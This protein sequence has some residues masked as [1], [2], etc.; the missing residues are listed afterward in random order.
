MKN[1][2]YLH[3]QFSY[4]V[5]SDRN[6]RVLEVVLIF[7]KIKIAINIKNKITFK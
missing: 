3:L 1:I 4:T 5:N 7:R 6:M 2:Y